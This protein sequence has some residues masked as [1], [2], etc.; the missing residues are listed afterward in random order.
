MK[1]IDFDILCE[2]LRSQGIT[3]FY[4]ISAHQRVTLREAGDRCVDGGDY[5]FYADIYTISYYSDGIRTVG[6]VVLN[7]TSSGFDYCAITGAFTDCDYVQFTISGQ[8]IYYLDI[9][10]GRY[11]VAPL[12]ARIDRDIHDGSGYH[13]ISHLISASSCQ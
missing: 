9:F 13:D 2:L 3:D 4:Y 5:G 12:D 11:I 7:D 8:L 1:P 6:D 10:Q